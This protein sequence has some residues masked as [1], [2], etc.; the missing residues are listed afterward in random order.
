[1][2][3]L[4]HNLL[5]HHFY[6]LLSVSVICAKSNAADNGNAFRWGY[7]GQDCHRNKARPI[8]LPDQKGGPNE[9]SI[10]LPF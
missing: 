1:M 3:H 5:D 7:G 9:L 10:P 6:G 2:P 8:S 4:I